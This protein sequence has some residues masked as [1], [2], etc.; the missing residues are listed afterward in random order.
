MSIVI[1]SV[2]SYL[3]PL[4]QDNRL[5][6][7]ELGFDEE[8]LLRKLG[9]IELPRMGPDQETSDLCVEAFRVLEKKTGINARD[10]DFIAVCTQ[11]PDGHGMPQTSAVVHGKLGLRERCAAFDISLACSGYAY[12]LSIARSF[13]QANSLKKGLLFTA[14]PYSKIL[15]I[16]DR[17]TALLFGDA[18]T[19]TLLDDSGQGWEPKRFLFATHGQHRGMVNNSSSKF[20][21]DGQGVFMFAMRAAPAEVQAI[22][23]E[24]GLTLEEVDLFVFHQGS[25][26][27]LESLR[28]HLGLPE[29]KVPIELNMAGNTVSS[30]IPLVLEGHLDRA[31]VKRVLCH[32]FGVGMSLGTCIIERTEQ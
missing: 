23:R 17:N 27:I 21:M 14:D 19:V 30:S 10:I 22:L 12:S 3:P 20:H 11:N 25:R 15:D 4:R 9:P 13:M 2:A 32:G 31:D 6:A 5:L 1:K 16:K 18:A 24:A 29:S 28:R 8:F 7:K 26:Y